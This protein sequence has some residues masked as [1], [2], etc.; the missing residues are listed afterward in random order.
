MLTLLYTAKVLFR[1]FHKAL[2]F[3]T[4][5]FLSDLDLWLSLP[6]GD[7]CTVFIVLFGHCSLLA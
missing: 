4:L 1:K 3:C 2:T 7:H 6:V 5:H